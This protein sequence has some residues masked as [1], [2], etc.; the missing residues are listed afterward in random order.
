VD[1]PVHIPDSGGNLIFYQPSIE[2]IAKIVIV[3]HLGYSM[4]DVFLVGV[5]QWEGTDPAAFYWDMYTTVQFFADSCLHTVRYDHALGLIRDHKVD[6]QSKTLAKF[7]AAFG[8]QTSYYNWAL[9]DLYKD[10]TELN[11]QTLFANAKTDGW[12]M[13]DVEWHDEWYNGL[14]E[15]DKHLDHNFV[16]RELMDQVLQEY[17]G[18]RLEDLPEESYAGLTYID[19]IG[20]YSV[21]A[22]DYSA[23][24]QFRAVG[25]EERENGE[26]W[27]Y[28]TCDGSNDLRVV[29]LRLSR[30]SNVP[31]QIMFNAE[32][33]PYLMYSTTTAESIPN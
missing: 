19:L 27:L 4:D 29:S 23:V 33:I 1:V 13:A 30:N 18:I 16:P 21:V 3:D 2:D 22:S 31:W 10:I 6:D 26:I 12:A 7:N 5:T 28:Y 15:T 25:L 17:F 24:E 11:L 8:D 9:V 32:Y 20:W 14:S